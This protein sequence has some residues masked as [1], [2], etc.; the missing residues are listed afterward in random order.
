MVTKLLSIFD[1]NQVTLHKW[2]LKVSE[3]GKNLSHHILRTL[4]PD[5]NLLAVVEKNVENFIM[6]KKISLDS[7][8][9]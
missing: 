5:V 3:N 6:N 2:V 9:F 1:K 8:H 4:H 7:I